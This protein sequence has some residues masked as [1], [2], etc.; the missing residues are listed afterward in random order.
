VPNSSAA[1]NGATARRMLFVRPGCILGTPQG[2]SDGDVLPRPPGD[3]RRDHSPTPAPVFARPGEV[4]LAPAIACSNRWNRE[5]L[6]PRG[7]RCR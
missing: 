2:P 5:R 6:G 7:C 4:N 3:G 1:T